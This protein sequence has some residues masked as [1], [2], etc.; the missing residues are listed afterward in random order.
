MA[1]NW[2]AVARKVIGERDELKR[3]LATEK[4]THALYRD[5]RK[6]RGRIRHLVGEFDLA[7]QDVNPE[8]RERREAALVEQLRKL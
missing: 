1:E 5:W 4:D 2:E 3:L 8:R 6:L 7:A